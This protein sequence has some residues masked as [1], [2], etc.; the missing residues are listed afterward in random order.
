MK[1]WIFWVVIIF[2]VLTTGLS[3]YGYQTI[4][5]PL[6]D[7]YEQA[8][9]Y[10]LG[11]SLLHTVSNGTYYHGTD[12]YYVFEGIMD[13]EEVI[14]WVSEEFDSHQI[15]KVSDGISEGEAISIVQ[16]QDEIKR[17]QSVKLGIERGLPVYEIIYVN[18]ENRKGY[19]YVTFEDGT[20]M[21]RYV[22]R[23][24]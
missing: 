2:V 11:Q 4:R 15:A 18:N 16:K 7:N 14:V 12:A 22:L 1:K 9:R 6:K 17:I 5:E 21:K 23:T 8:E 10:V 13:E 3:V 24:D 20:F 19:Y